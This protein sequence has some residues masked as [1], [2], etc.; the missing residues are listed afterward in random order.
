MLEQPERPVRLHVVA[1]ARPTGLDRL[2]PGPTRLD[3]FK[4]PH[5]GSKANVDRELLERVTCRR[6][7]VSTSGA[8]FGH[9][10]REAMARVIKFGGPTPTLCFNFASAKNR[11]WDDDTLRADHGYATVY[12]EAGEEGLAVEL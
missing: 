10:D 3:A 1:K 11:V 5:H 8:V 6:Y 7:L 9:P 12:P 4:L 2:G